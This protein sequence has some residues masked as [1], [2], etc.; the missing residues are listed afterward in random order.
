MNN[1][2]TYI[3]LAPKLLSGIVNWNVHIRNM[4]NAKF[5][6]HV[7]NTFMEYLF[8]IFN[9]IKTSLRMHITNTCI[10]DFS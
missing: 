10:E 9:I 1:F 6:T 5:I 2:L 3:C 7:R 8:T 4:G